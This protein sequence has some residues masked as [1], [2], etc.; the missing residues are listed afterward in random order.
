MLPDPQVQPT[1]DVT[2]F[3]IDFSPDDRYLAVK[4]VDQV[5]RRYDLSNGSVLTR[6]LPTDAAARVVH[7]PDGTVIAVD[8]TYLYDAA[9]LRPIAGRLRPEHWNDPT[10]DV[11]TQSTAFQSGPDGSLHLVAERASDTEA[12]GWRIDIDGLQAQSCSIAGRNL[13]Q[14]EFDL[15]GVGPTY[16]PTCP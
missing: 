6:Q 3:G 11:G 1:A 8:G 7:S 10:R 16:R 13:T 4:S 12:V 9:T 2:L 5:L 14:D 15:Y